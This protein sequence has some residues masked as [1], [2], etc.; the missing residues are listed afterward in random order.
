MPKAKAEKPRAKSAHPKTTKSVTP[1][2]RQTA[3]KGELRSKSR[4][5]SKA[6]KG[7]QSKKDTQ[8]VGAL[9]FSAGDYIAFVDPE[10]E[11]PTQFKIG[12]LI[13]DVKQNDKQVFCEAFV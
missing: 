2:K 9:A 1:S 13:S 3:P 10:S 4:S 12:L 6:S 8:S 7:K 11:D 5:P